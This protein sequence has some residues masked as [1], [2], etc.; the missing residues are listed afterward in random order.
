MSK[1]RIVDRIQEMLYELEVRSV[2]WT[3]YF[4]LH[5][6][7]MMSEVW[8]TMKQNN[9]TCVP[10]VLDD[11]L[12]GTMTVDSYTKWL[13]SHEKDVPVTRYMTV[14]HITLHPQEPV[15]SALRKMSE[16]HSIRVPV[17]DSDTYELVGVICRCNLFEDVLSHI[18]VIY[19]DEEVRH[20]RAS[21][22]FED[23]HA[24]TVNITLRYEVSDTPMEFGGE[25][26][27]NL[28]TS[29]QN[30]GLDSDMIRKA[31]IATYEAEM[32]LLAYAGGGKFRVDVNPE[33]VRIV[34]TDSGPGIPDIDQALTPGFSTAPDW[35]RELGFGAGMGLNNI[36]DCSD[37]FEI[38]S[39]VG[40]GT[41]LDIII[42]LE[43]P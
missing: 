20:Y 3:E 8:K 35:V 5:P 32:N 30:L 36:Q 38:V 18:D 24:D 33:H 39:E 21:H 34:V 42:D 12:I 40:K 29:L 22:I 37:S 23:V 31:G 41:A 15:I 4:T 26:A 10:I 17:V 25:V 11:K 28:R 1:I 9:Y 43:T 14:D 13:K 7:Q 27:S 19:K 6:H 16:S 2:M